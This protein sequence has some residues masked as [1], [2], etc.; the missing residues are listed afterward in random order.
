[1]IIDERTNVCTTR[2]LA[3]E[4]VR[5]TERNAKYAANENAPFAPHLSTNHIALL[6]RSFPSFHLVFR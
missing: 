1:M 3:A 6:R 5:W 4:T 2:E